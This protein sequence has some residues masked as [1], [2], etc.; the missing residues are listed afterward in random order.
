VKYN[1]HCEEGRR[2]NL[3]VLLLEYAWLRV[4]RAI[5]RNDKLGKTLQF[6]QFIHLFTF[7]F[8]EYFHRHRHIN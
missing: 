6:K 8:A 7:L 2:S 5:A 4:C 3:V 1:C